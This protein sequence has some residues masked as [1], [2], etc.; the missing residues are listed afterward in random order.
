MGKPFAVAGPRLINCTIVPIEKLT[1]LRVTAEDQDVVFVAGRVFVEESLFG[2]A[3]KMG[4]LLDVALGELDFGNPAA[5][6]ALAAI[7]SV[8]DLFSRL[9]KLA[10]YEHPRLHILTEAAVFI[11]LL[12]AEP[13]NLHQVGYHYFQVTITACLTVYIFLAACGRPAK[14][15]YS[16]SLE[17]C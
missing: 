4:Q 17:S 16:I 5:F 1:T 2:K 11:P 6:G 9:A 8:G 15:K 13:L 14:L 10:L 7:D 12:L 3:Q